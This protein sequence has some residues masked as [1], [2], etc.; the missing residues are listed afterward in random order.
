[1]G[2]LLPDAITR[3]LHQIGRLFGQLGVHMAPILERP[4]TQLDEPHTL[5]RNDHPETSH[6]AARRVHLRTGTARRRVMEVLVD[7]QPW[8][9]SDEDIADRL[10]MSLNTVRPRRVELV[11]AGYVRDSQDQTVTRT[12]CRSILWIATA[13]GETALEE[14][15]QDQVR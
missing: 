12:G 6:A 8:G 13:A 15:E 1:M 4:V 14:A 9:L 11:R 10:R 7:A 5:T 3:H 2:E